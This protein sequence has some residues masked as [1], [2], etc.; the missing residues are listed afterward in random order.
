MFGTESLV[1]IDSLLL[2]KHEIVAELPACLP[3]TE[4]LA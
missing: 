1:G 4:E 3:G 2:A